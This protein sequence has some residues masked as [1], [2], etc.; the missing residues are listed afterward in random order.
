MSTIGVEGVTRRSVAL[1]TR[2]LRPA[3]DR[4]TLIVRFFRTEALI[5]MVN[6]YNIST[7]P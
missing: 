1:R 6:C 4:C 7:T 5:I 3:R 2:R